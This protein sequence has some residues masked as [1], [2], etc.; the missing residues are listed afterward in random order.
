MFLAAFATS[1][2]GLNRPADPVVLTGSD[3][4]SLI[5]AGVGNVVGFRYQGGWQQIPIQIDERDLVDLAKPYNASATG[6]TA[7]Q[8]SD[9][10]TF[11]GADSNPL[12]DGN[13]ELVFM[14]FDAGGKASGAE[15]AGVIAGSGLELHIT[16]PIEGSAG[17][18]YLFRTNGS[19]PPGAGQQYVNYDFNVVGCANY[20]SCYDLGGANPENSTVT[21][22]AYALH[23]S[24]MWV[25]DGLQITVGGS[26]GTDFLDRQR[27]AL[28]PNSDVR[29]EDTFSFSRGCFVASRGGPVRAL[30][31]FM[32]SN[33]GVYNQL[34]QVFYA[35]RMDQTL[36][37]RVHPM[38][39]AGGAFDYTAQAIGMR[40]HSN[41][42]PGGVTIDGVPDAIS[43]VAT[44]WD[45]VTGSHG[46]LVVAYLPAIHDI[47]T[48]QV[49]TYYTDQEPPAER[50]NTGDTHTYCVHGQWYTGI[51]NTDPTR[52]QDPLY[53]L[54]V[55][56]VFYFDGPDKA[57]SDAEA[58][59]QLAA[60][61][62]AVA[63]SAYDPTT[64][65]VAPS[66]PSLLHLDISPNPVRGVT[67]ITFGLPA[68]GQ[69]EVS[70]YDFAG[71]KVATIH[72]G[73]AEAGQHSQIWMGRSDSGQA[74]PPGV[75]FVRL[76]TKQGTQVRRLALVR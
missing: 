73:H 9:P 30:R 2:Q 63:V 18:V 72:H 5:G 74:L 27:I 44:T 7:L 20:R 21:T 54:T 59:Y 61:N 43:T 26:T 64:T 8:Y 11:T 56:E 71:R 33:S 31:C 3:V 29:N 60:T 58:C 76:M 34:S 66:S 22:A 40:Y 52:V 50:Q 15:P 75:Y 68:S 69:A 62:L 51:P 70:I 19:L 41:V 47:P 25:H 16:D 35:R 67:S 32:G 45:M 13:D 4:G 38:Y 65:D 1:A 49:Q 48:L 24:E 6:F 12:F 57:V 36:N 17:Y 14:A 39:S 23:F 28:S 42:H 53:H 55:P 46:T 37:H 10:N